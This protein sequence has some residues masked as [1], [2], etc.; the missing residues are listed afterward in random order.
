MDQQ[1]QS[2]AGFTNDEAARISRERISFSFG[3]NWK[4]LVPNV[5]EAGL[6]RAVASFVK[7]T[8][9][10][11]LEGHTVLD[12]GCGSGLSSLVAVSLGATRVVS[13]DVD[14][15]C[16]ECVTGLREK[17]GAQA[18]RW[19]VAM[20]SVLD[21]RFVETLGRFSYVYSWGVL[22]HTGA[23]WPAIENA[24][25]CLSDGG[26]FHLALYNSHKNSELWHRIKRLCNRSPRLAYPLL[27]GCYKLQAYARVLAGGRSIRQFNAEYASGRGMSFHR[28]V[29]DWFM[30]LPYE[31]CRP[32]EVFDFLSERGMTLSRLRTAASIGCNE[33]LFK[34]DNGRLNEAASKRALEPV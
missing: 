15:N 29:E 33:F 12:L 10:R 24:A 23:M 26:L 13:V 2:L 34:M 30:G 21:T 7:F 3:R 14:P 32:E 25:K 27:V 28:D 17:F 22:H 1:P 9:L 19:D 20:G 11:T 5:D 18:S 6:E 31:F 16:I 4:K 8:H